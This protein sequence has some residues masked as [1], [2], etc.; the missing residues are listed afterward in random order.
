MFSGEKGFEL[1]Q[2]LDLPLGDYSM[3]P[4]YSRD[5]KVFSTGHGLVVGIADTPRGKRLSVQPVK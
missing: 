4:E 3:T 5:G 1:S 2:P